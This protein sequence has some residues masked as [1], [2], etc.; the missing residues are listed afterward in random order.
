MV[1]GTPYIFTIVLESHISLHFALR[2]AVFALQVIL[3]QVHQMT[4]KRPWTL[5]GQ[6]YPYMCYLCPRVPKTSVRFALSPA[7]FELRAILRKVHRMTPKLTLDS[8][9]ANVRHIFV[10]IHK[11]QISPHFALRPALF[12]IQCTKWPQNDLEVYKIK[13]TPHMSY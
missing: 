5:Q 2:P 13:G 9:R 12:E 6:M 10:S 1:I 4:A 7:V 11:S 3:R 8:T